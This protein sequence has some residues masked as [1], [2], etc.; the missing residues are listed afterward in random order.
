MTEG[1]GM[2][3]DGTGIESNMPVQTCESLLD[4][5]NTGRTM[6]IIDEKGR[7][8]IIRRHRCSHTEG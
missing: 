8:N 6:K 7:D 5:C 1:D 2:R 3:D 4:I